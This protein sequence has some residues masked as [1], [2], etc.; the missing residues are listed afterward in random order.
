MPRRRE[1]DRG[2]RDLDAVYLYYQA[3]GEKN[4]GNSMASRDLLLKAHRLD[5]LDQDTLRELTLSYREEVLKQT[6]LKNW[7]EA[8][9][10]LSICRRYNKAMQ[11]PVFKEVGMKKLEVSIH[12]GRKS[13]DMEDGDRT[14]IARLLNE[15]PDNEKDNW[16]LE[17]QA[18]LE[19]MANSYDSAERCLR[20]ALRLISNDNSIIERSCNLILDHSERSKGGARKCLLTLALNLNKDS[21]RA[22]YLMASKNYDDGEIDQAITNLTS[23]G[24]AGNYKRKVHFL[25]G[26]CYFNKG[27]YKDAECEFVQAKQDPRDIDVFYM[28]GQTFEMLG[29]IARARERYAEV[30]NLL[31]SYPQE[32]QNK[33]SG[34][35]SSLFKEVYQRASNPPKKDLPT[36]EYKRTLFGS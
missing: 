27:R 31:R 2:E 35:N 3:L 12:R 6:S 11:V 30:A 18:D 36:G 7:K 34:F 5:P 20:S 14:K 23:I 21:V 19:L 32:Y 8:T 28:L 29:E 9:E 24:D 33:L 4:N 15:I 13:F 22:R 26:T 16:M 25:L 1:I 10:M 17:Q